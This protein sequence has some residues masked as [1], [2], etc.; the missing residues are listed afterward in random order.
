MTDYPVAPPDNQAAWSSRTFTE[1]GTYTSKPYS[2]IYA[3]VVG[4]GGYGTD[5][6]GGDSGACV[7]MLRVLR[8]SY[9]FHF[10]VGQAGTD[11]GQASRFDTAIA[12]G[13]ASGSSTLTLGKAYGGDT[14]QQ[15]AESAGVQGAEGFY[16]YGAGGTNGPGQSGVVYILERPLAP[17]EIADLGEVAVEAV[18]T[19]GET[20]SP[21]TTYGAFPD[22]ELFYAV[23]EFTSTGSPEPGF[24]VTTSSDFNPGTYPPWHVLNRRYT[25]NSSHSWVSGSG[26]SG[27][28]WLQ[29]TF[30]TASRI[31][32]YSIRGWAQGAHYQ[33]RSWHILGSRDGSSWH[34]LHRVID[35]PELDSANGERRFQLT[36]VGEYR[37]YRLVCT[38]TYSNSTQSSIFFGLSTFDL[39][40]V[41]PETENGWYVNFPSRNPQ[42][43]FSPPQTRGWWSQEFTAEGVYQLDIPA[44]VDEALVILIGGS[45]DGS[46]SF[47]G[48]S[49]AMT[50]LRYPLRGK[51]TAGIA[52][53]QVGS[54][55]DASHFDFNG[56]EFLARGGSHA[57]SNGPG[58]AGTLDTEHS[59]Y[60]ALAGNPGSG[61]QGGAP[62]DTNFP[63][64][65][66]AAAGKTGS[67]GYALV[68]LRYRYPS[69]PYNREIPGWKKHELAPG[70]IDFLLNAQDS[71]HFL[72]AIGRGGKGALQTDPNQGAGGGSAG[73]HASSRFY[74]DGTSPIK[75][76]LGQV[77]TASNGNT[78]ILT[79]AGLRL[80]KAPPGTEGTPTF[81]AFGPTE[82]HLGEFDY[83]AGGW[84]T[85]GRIGP[86]EGQGGYAPLDSGYGYGGDSSLVEAETDP[87][88][89][90]AFIFVRDEGRQ[91]NVNVTKSST[92]ILHGYAGGPTRIA[93]SSQKVVTV[94]YR[95]PTR[96]STASEHLL[97]AYERN[98]INRLAMQVQ[99]V[100]LKDPAQ[101]TNASAVTQHL[102]QAYERNPIT[103][104][105]V[106]SQQVLL[107]TAPVP[108]R[109]TRASL[110]VL[111]SVE[112]IAPDEWRASQVATSTLHGF[113]GLPTYTNMAMLDVLRYA[114][115]AEQRLSSVEIAVL[116]LDDGSQVDVSTHELAIMM[117]L[118]RPLPE[119][120]YISQVLR[121]D[122]IKKIP[123]PTHT[124][125]AEVAILEVVEEP[126]PD[127]YRVNAS[128]V[129]VLQVIEPPPTAAATTYQASLNAA[130]VGRT[131]YRNPLLIRSPAQSD[132]V[133]SRLASGMPYPNPDTLHMPIR[134][135]SVF[136]NQVSGIDD[137]FDPYK[138]WSHS[139]A[140]YLKQDI[141]WAADYRDPHLPA[142]T[143]HAD[144]LLGHVAEQA[145]YRDPHV[146]ASTSQIEQIAANYV[147]E[148]WYP[149][150]DDVTSGY[151]VEQIGFHIGSETLYPDP[152]LPASAVDSDYVTMVHAK[153]LEYVD[154]FLPASDIQTNGVEMIVAIPADATPDVI[155]DPDEPLP[156][157]GQLVTGV[158]IVHAHPADYPDPRDYD[159]MDDPRDPAVPDPGLAVNGVE[160]VHAYPAVYPAPP[161]DRES[162]YPDPYGVLSAGE[163]NG[164]EIV[165]ASRIDYFDPYEIWTDIQVS[166]IRQETVLSGDYPHALMP[167][168]G[169]DANDLA[170]Y[171][172]SRGQY[173]D[174]HIPQSN[175]RAQGIAGYILIQPNYPDPLTIEPGFVASQLSMHHASPSTYLDKDIPQSTSR[176]FTV[177]QQVM[178]YANDD[179]SGG[180]GEPYPD[181]E[182]V[183]ELAHVDYYMKQVVSKVQYEDRSSMTQ[184]NELRQVVLTPATFE[185]PEPPERKRAIFT[186]RWIPG[187]QQD[188][189]WQEH[190]PD[191]VDFEHLINY[192]LPPS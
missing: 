16:G 86:L 54:A 84:G 103:R 117:V 146:P 116:M 105:A 172:L 127:Y 19:G 168:S 107:R 89:A 166:Q 140:D 36:A 188:D 85:D 167:Q 192:G 32:H 58:V 159:D 151:T 137:Y 102:I 33:P 64:L 182:D 110:D 161:R 111:I 160:I 156:D 9:T 132:S 30:P 122:L 72:V 63:R 52:T 131:L 98:P 96:I 141:A 177:A 95:L 60:L 44:E 15:G 134:A 39:L 144:S 6:K 21:V 133:E 7:E 180:G 61:D 181:P 171:T 175:I 4:A 154:P 114:D 24:I 178:G 142:S 18:E 139:Q 53:I 187:H 179:G 104:I 152:T 190:Y 76:L 37:H 191:D 83:F 185:T 100:I 88:E 106:Q 75:R 5:A 22:T 123:D 10:E 13:G 128:L 109:A 173:R 99:Q 34:E 126:L 12:E 78:E 150:P 93:T 25:S 77:G 42:S 43:P 49:G 163:V 129:E 47:G 55:G 147:A 115:N 148:R 68:L 97:Q 66:G 41:Q 17:S 1:S 57:D 135:E 101:A 143:I 40:I 62:A 189:G 23:P 38:D 71:E 65:A 153:E 130:Q 91:D 46:T 69:P 82:S 48:G 138:V 176:V 70:P 27:E 87:G 11:Y 80:V 183:V 3:I 113:P 186:Q 155:D 158:E 108:T 14:R 121:H 35:S 51:T 165:D 169:I 67:P 184:V 124:S 81:G 112:P 74:A 50:A 26:E 120:P 125:A 118:D 145:D 45:G 90:V 92:D 29:V 149:H 157:S 2:A 174:A 136:L 73:S 59:Y 79:D 56:K 162:G 170:N 31:T 20:I 94:G 8:G 164:I 119:R 28:E